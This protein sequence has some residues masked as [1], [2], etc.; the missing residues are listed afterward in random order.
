MRVAFINSVAGFGS[1][2]RLVYRLSRIDGVQ[3]RIYYGRKKNLTDADVYRITDFFGNAEHAF[4]T[5]L[6]DEQGF[7]NRR[8]TE[9]MVSNLKEF[10]PDLIHLHNLHGYYLDAEVLFGYLKESGKPVI[11][12]FHD[13]W[14]FTGHCAHYD[15]L[16]CEKWKTECMKCPGL[17]QYPVTWNGMN[18]RKNY[19][20]KKELFNSLG[21]QLTIV[22]P[23]FWLESQ[24]RQSFLKDNDIRTI[25][26]GIDL[27]V[28]HPR[29]TSFRKE[30]HL[31][32][33]FLILAV[34]SI[35]NKEKGFEDLLKLR[36]Q[37]KEPQKLIAVGVTPAQKRKLDSP[38]V[39]CIPRTDS[40][41]ELCQ[42]YS[43]ADVLINLTYE[44]TFP[45][46]NLEALACGCPVVTFETGGSPEAVTDRT[47]RV[48]AQGD[49]A[50]LIQQLSDLQEGKL[51][52]NRSDCVRRG[53]RFSD[54]N[55]LNSYRVLYEERTG[56]AL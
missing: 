39:L 41:D 5:F 13:C 19:A 15:C 44:D 24:V 43:S 20:R 18:V 22:T 27:S 36:D 26:N 38:K 35:W 56:Y 6:A 31:E 4:R 8:E 50:G 47:G 48:I 37:L 42:I 52:L 1:T 53:R 3:G 7:A 49:L 54:V 34:A 45:T 28:F 14:P 11:W 29:E 10:N 55:M 17:N 25:H 40:V 46:V 51:V 23:S 12:T 16:H 32:D 33:S 9:R 2:G 30:H 21:R